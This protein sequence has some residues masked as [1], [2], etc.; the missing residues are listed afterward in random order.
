MRFIFNI[1]ASATSIYLFLI[2]ARIMLTWFSGVRYSR[3]AA[4]LSA[5]TDPYL[6]WFR[7]LPGLRLG[8][9]LDISPIIAMSVLSIA[10]NV[11]ITMASYGY[12]TAGFVIA[13]VVKSLW[14]AISFLLGFIVIVL[15]L[16]LFAYLTRQNIF[17]PFWRIVDAI[18]QPPLYRINALFY[19]GRSVQYTL[20]IITALVVF[21]AAWI[22]GGVAIN[23]VSSFL[24]RLPI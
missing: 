14:S 13:L 5:M 1:L 17:S 18:S 20:V 24:L 9:F 22:G 19:G 2:F 21:L 10:N 12:V 3:P 4:V 11:F 8:G 16:R 7:Q 15:G 23:I 6:D